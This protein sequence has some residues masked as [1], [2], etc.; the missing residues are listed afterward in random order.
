MMKDDAIAPVI[1]VMLILAAVVTVYTIWNAVYVPAEKGASEVEHLKNVESAFQHFS[2]DI[3]FAVSSHQNHLSFSEPVQL[4]GG[5]VSVNLLKSSGTLQVQ[6]ES[7]PLYNITFFNY[8]T[9]Q[10]KIVPV[11]TDD[12]TI[13]NFSYEPTGNFWQDQG[14]QWQYGYINVTKY[15]SLKSPLGYYNMTNVETSLISKNLKA[16]AQSYVW[17]E[18]S[19]NQSMQLECNQSATNDCSWSNNWTY[20]SFQ[21]NC[22]S[23]DIYAVKMTAAPDHTF[24]SSNGYGTLRLESTFLR[25]QSDDEVKINNASGISFGSDN[26]RFGNATIDSLNTSLSIINQTC[27]QNLM[28]NLAGTSSETFR[29]WDIRQDISPVNVTLHIVNIEVGA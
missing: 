17:T 20:K 19:V 29:R 5:D 3:E 2:S 6:N 12:W 27:Y 23:L 14:Y 15:G 21:G 4:G 7:R 1:A 24:V 8:N 22:T 13:I 28:Y 18:Y 10:N 11:I 25:P 26:S 16:L 9:T